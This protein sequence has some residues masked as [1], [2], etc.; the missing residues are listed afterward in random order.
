MS[1]ASPGDAALLEP[2]SSS[3]PRPLRAPVPPPLALPPPS[4]PPPGVSN[5]SAGDAPPL[6]RGPPMGAAEVT[7]GVVAPPPPAEAPEAD[8]A[9][10]AAPPLDEGSET[11]SRYGKALS[12]L[13][14]APKVNFNVPSV[15]KACRCSFW[16]AKF[17]AALKRFPFWYCKS[18]ARYPWAYLIT[19]YIIVAIIIS[20][21]WRPV[22]I[23]TDIEAFREVAGEAAMMQRSY[24][25]ALMFQKA[26]KANESL[27][28]R[29]TFSV[30][31][32]YEAKSGSVFSEAALRDI[33]S[34]EQGLRNL[35]GWKKMCDMSDPNATWRCEPGESLG[36]YAW[37]DRELVQSGRHT[38]FILKFSGAS[39][40]RLP[41][42]A[43]LTYLHEGRA[44]PHDLRKFLPHQFSAPQHDSTLLRSVFA[45]TAPSLDHGTFSTA[46]KEFIEEELFPAL[47]N[48]TLLAEET[49]DDLWIEPS[50][51]RIYFRGEEIEA[52]EVRYFLE[53]DLKY[54]IGALVITFAITWLQLRSAFLAIIGLTQ[55]CLV[56]LIAFVTV[57]IG[58]LSL[59]SFL[60]IFLVIGLSSNDLMAIKEYWRR[61]GR[62]CS[63]Y[64]PTSAGG[65]ARKE[66]SDRYYAIRLSRTFPALFIRFLPQSLTMVSWLVLLSSLIRPVR[67]FG[68]FMFT[69]MAFSSILCIFMFPPLLVLHEAYVEPFV[70]QRLHRIPAL[71]LEPTKL[72]FPWRPLV[73]QCLK[74]ATPRFA[75]LIWAGTA[76][77]ALLCF[78][79]A[80]VVVVLSDN[81]GLPEVYANGHHMQAGRSRINSFAP[82]APALQPAPQ[83]TEVCEPRDGSGTGNC[84]LHWCE[85][86]AV[87]EVP[88]VEE[89]A[90]ASV[91]PAV[92]DVSCNCHRTAPVNCDYVNLSFMIMGTAFSKANDSVRM[93]SLNGFLQA[94]FASSNI[95]ILGSTG[96]ARSSLVLEHWESG[97][98]SLEPVTEMPVAFIQTRP[99]SGSFLNNTC[100]TPVDCFCGPRSCDASPGVYPV[101]FDTPMIVPAAT[102]TGRRLEQNAEEIAAVKEVIIVFGLVAPEKHDFLSGAS[103][104]EFDDTFEPVSPWAQRAMLKMCTNIP[105]S[106]GVV[107]SHCWIQEFRTWLSSQGE[108]FP[109]ERF[110][111]FQAKLRRFLTE[112]PNTPVTAMWLDAAGDMRAT[113]F[114]FKVPPKPKASSE[115]QLKDRDAWLAYIVRENEM[116]ATAASQA[117][118]TSTYWTEAEAQHEAL[119]NAWQV[120]GTAIAICIAACILYTWDGA[121][122][123]TVCV[124][125]F[126]VVS[127]VGFV[128]FC[129]FQ[130][131]IGPWE[132]ILL[133]AFLM[134]TI[135]PALRIGRGT[136]WGEWF[137]FETKMSGNAVA[138]LG[139]LQN[140]TAVGIAIQ[141][142]QGN[143][144]ALA[145]PSSLAAPPLAVEDENLQNLDAPGAEGSSN[146]S[147]AGGRDEA[148]ARSRFEGR[149]HQFVLNA[150]NAT[151]GS[152]VKLVLCG[153]LILPCEFRLFSRLGAVSIMVPLVALPCIFIL[154]PTAFVLLPIR[155]QPDLVTAWQMFWAKYNA[156]YADS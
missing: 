25:E 152:A 99:A 135:E 132:I 76:V 110:G 72:R 127:F 137:E 53:S 86:P 117:W 92:T 12:K 71:I 91:G 125:C 20:V 33:R 49:P 45:F 68:L 46:Y 120:A 59:A 18:V 10:V 101:K 121:F 29:A 119:S 43:F 6:L 5:A 51:V 83:Q 26:S 14:R 9:L 2:A 40:E 39:R 56:P 7:A 130:W 22:M 134:Y 47:R 30:E 75:R 64:Y 67:E 60:C 149:M 105:E 85:A 96:K 153:F 73:R 11:Q 23:N 66:E 79:I 150:S 36:N 116:S 98:T 145:V 113:A 42:P 141:D 129:I 81:A 27:A 77:A 104:W 31:L 24:S 61:V 74:L 28:D 70:T 148:E 90:T 87:E 136:V 111:D 108:K 154:V 100:L 41:V 95:S 142:E 115:E 133:I 32:F 54:A 156:Y 118:A 114:A 21:A 146:G 1:N 48:A 124:I 37:P 50:S 123:A 97:A 131:A 8:L 128:V 93:N 112:Q 80:T 34:V 52:H 155:E 140:R 17:R 106:F 122:V 126:F 3:S 94:S 144:S 65:L 151:F 139:A 138:P 63:Q 82:T 109:I 78:G 57:N 107:E 55:V 88:V 13:P 102:A 103:K 147:P 16:K 4:V 35:P 143:T 84:G 19:Y 15:P 58:D 62:D 44:Q 69:S 89:N 38:P